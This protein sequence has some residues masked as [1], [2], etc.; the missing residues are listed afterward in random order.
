MAPRTRCKGFAEEGGS[1][2]NVFKIISNIA[3]KVR[4]RKVG[5]SRSAVWMADRTPVQNQMKQ[6]HSSDQARDPLACHVF[7]KFCMA[8]ICVSS[9]LAVYE[10]L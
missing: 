9:N 1:D 7:G 10:V 8:R 6:L 2:I 4:I 3:L 5:E